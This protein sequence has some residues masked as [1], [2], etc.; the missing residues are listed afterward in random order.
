MVSVCTSMASRIFSLWSA[1]ARKGLGKPT[2]RGNNPHI[3]HLPQRAGQARTRRVLRNQPSPVWLTLALAGSA[4][5][6]R[7]R[8]TNPG[9]SWRA[10]QWHGFRIF[11]HITLGAFGVTR[12]SV[13]QIYSLL[14]FSRRPSLSR[15]QF[16]DAEI[17]EMGVFGLKFTI[18]LEQL[19]AI[20]R[21]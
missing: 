12:R 19:M 21:Q 1:K 9:T 2:Y 20:F 5:V 6:C 8:R 15:P 7:A 13:V 17:A 10:Y 11:A 18:D 4:R 3:D 14:L 16:G